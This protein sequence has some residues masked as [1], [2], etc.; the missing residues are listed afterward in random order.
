MSSVRLSV[1]LVERVRRVAARRGLKVS[2]VHRRALAEYCERELADAPQGR[3]DD[4]IGVVE[5]PPDLAERASE[6]F[7]DL[8]VERRG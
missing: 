2:E 8:L 1:E 5:G 3:F 4:V 6:R 7:T